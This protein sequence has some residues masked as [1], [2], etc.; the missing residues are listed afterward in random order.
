MIRIFFFVLLENFGTPDLDVTS[1]WRIVQ[2]DLW[3]AS[4]LDFARI[5]KAYTLIF[6]DNKETVPDSQW[7]NDDFLMF[8]S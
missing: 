7:H 8:A 4:D 5:S 1:Q 3:L 2:Q 6:K